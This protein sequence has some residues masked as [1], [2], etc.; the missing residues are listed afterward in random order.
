MA[1]KKAPAAAGFK[2]GDT[3]I[4]PTGERGKVVSV[5]KGIARVELAKHTLRFAVAELRAC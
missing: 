5:A 3:V 4:A 1:S 2:K